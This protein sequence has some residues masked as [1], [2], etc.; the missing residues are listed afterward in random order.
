MDTPSSVTSPVTTHP[1]GS[2]STPRMAYLCFETAALYW[3]AVREGRL[4]F[5]EPLEETTLTDSCVTS[6]RELSLIDFSPLGVRLGRDGL[7]GFTR[8]VKTRRRTTSENAPAVQER[9]MPSGLAIA[10]GQSTPIH[11][12]TNNHAQRGS[13]RCIRIHLSTESLPP[14]S[15]YAVTDQ[16]RVT[17]PELTLLHLA[18]SLRLLP[19]IE[20]ACEWCGT[21]ALGPVTLDCEFDCMP[22]TDTTRLRGLVRQHPAIRGSSAVRQMLRRIGEGLASPSE[23]AVFLLLTLPSKLGGFGIPLPLANQQIPLRGTPFEDLS[24]HLYFVA[25]LLWYHATLIVEYDGKEDHELTPQ[26]IAEDKERRSVLAA[27]GYTVIVI[28]RH[29]LES[30]HAFRRKARQIAL[31]LGVSLPE[32]EGSEANACRALFNWLCDAEHDHVPFG[33]GYR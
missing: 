31:A 5:P 15:L 17:S 16:I 21:Y 24:E 6:F 33:F 10:F 19:C 18:R 14:G 11:V 29:D 26:K 13:C 3:R 30:L 22:I 4:P 8:V 2:S 23:T 7:S 12:M 20:L 28:T 9:I 1:T 32:P 27:M 25:D